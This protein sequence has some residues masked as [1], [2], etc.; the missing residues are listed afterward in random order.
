MRGPRDV[1]IT[2][3]GA[4]EIGVPKIVTP[5]PPEVILVSARVMVAANT[6]VVNVSP[7]M[8]NC[9][10]CGVEGA[11]GGERAM[12]EEPTTRVR[13]GPRDTGVPPTVMAGAPEA[14]VEPFTIT[15][16]G[17]TSTVFPATVIGAAA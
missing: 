5:G 16:L 10:G 2:P 8:E 15:L 6:A 4:S 7:P 3:E 13:E 14:S 12:F 9:A 17:L 11:C 1:P